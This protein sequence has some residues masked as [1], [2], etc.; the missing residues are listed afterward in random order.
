M[1]TGPL[2]VWAITFV[3]T[4]VAIAITIFASRRAISHMKEESIVDK[5]VKQRQNN[6]N[7]QILKEKYILPYLKCDPECDLDCTKQE[8]ASIE[9]SRRS[10]KL[11]QE[12]DVVL[13]ASCVILG[14]EERT[15]FTYAKDNA[16]ALRELNGRSAILCP[17]HYLNE[18]YLIN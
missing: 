15:V 6:I 2:L 14:C 17:W 10:T 12:S 7:A 18:T 13:D 4:L 8:C 9:R 11:E 1:N 3:G 16:Y 5:L